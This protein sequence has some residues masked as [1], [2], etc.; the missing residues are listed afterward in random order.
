MRNT[1]FFLLFLLASLNVGA[2]LSCDCGPEEVEVQV[3]FTRSL[4][5]TEWDGL[6]YCDDSPFGSS[7]EVVNQNGTSI[8]AGSYFDNTSFCTNKNDILTVYGFDSDGQGWS[9]DDLV[10]KTKLGVSFFTFSPSGSFAVS[11]THLRAHETD[12]YLVC[13]CT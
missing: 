8:I 5:G 1:F 7:W 12:S 4:C 13:T 3:E 6:Y 9:G 10:F 2:Q 11:Y